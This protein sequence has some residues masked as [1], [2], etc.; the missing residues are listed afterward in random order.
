MRCK[1]EVNDGLFEAKKSSELCFNDTMLNFTPR[2][3]SNSNAFFQGHGT[4]VP[5]S[6]LGCGAFSILLRSVSVAVQLHDLT[7]H[8]TEF[9][10]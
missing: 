10:L 4:C 7:P 5:F 3:V 1:D 6:L 9:L 8:H 2:S